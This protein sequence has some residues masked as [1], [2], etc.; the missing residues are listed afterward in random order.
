MPELQMQVAQGNSQGITAFNGLN[1]AFSNQTT[2]PPVPSYPGHSQQQHQVS[3]QQSHGLSSP[4]HPHLQG[5]N[6]A[7]GSQQQA[8]AIRLAKERQLQ[9]RYLQQQQ[10]Q[11]QQQQFA[12]S[13]AMM[14]HVQSQAHLPVSSSLQN[15]SQIQSQTPAQPVSLSPL[16]PSSPL[17][18]IPAQHQQKHHLP[19][20]L[21]RNP[22]ASGLTNQMGKQ[23]QRQQQQQHL[24]QTGRH[25]PQ[26]RQHVQS[27]Q[28][29]KLLKGVGRGLVQNL[30]VDPSHL[31]GLSMPQGSQSLEKGEQIMQLVPGQGVYSGSGLNTM[32]PPKTMVPQSSNHSQLQQKVLA[33]SA[34]PSTKQLQQMASHSD[35]T[36]QGQVPPI[37][38]CPTLSS[39]HQVVPAAVM[40]SSHQQLQPQSQP[41]QKQVNQIQPNVQRMIQQNR[42]VNSE[43]PNKS[44]NDVAQAEQLPVNNTSQVGASMAI[45]QS[46]MDSTVAVPVSSAI[47]PQWKPS[48]PVFD[49]NIPNSTIQAG[50]VGSPSLSNSSG[51]EPTPPIS[52]GLGPRQLSGSLPSHG[53]N[54]GIQWPQQQQQ[55]P[56]SQPLQQSPTLPPAS[57]QYMQQEQQPEQKSSQNQLPL[58]QQH[59]QQIQHRQAG[60]GSLYL[61]PANSKPE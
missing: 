5:P 26:Q 60:Q 52:Q 58:Q 34:P 51:N 16:T 20:G 31:N 17:T 54:V 4:H 57:Q 21:S 43:L 46:C 39:S 36:T 18:P 14:S 45:P 23:R 38:S 10:Q 11:Q 13:N 8:Y 19:H 7:T 25:H 44:Q 49:S 1:A 22:G 27:Q 40:S 37:S 9:Q 41:H 55:P 61:R 48:E 30:S 53:H 47:T 32:Q 12:G 29:A 2:P 50:S 6:H 42:Q 15:S 3:P 59:Q 33:S 28:Q 35:T 24:Q 56:P